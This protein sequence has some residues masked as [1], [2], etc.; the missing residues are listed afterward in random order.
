MSVTEPRTGARARQTFFVMWAIVATILGLML[1]GLVVLLFFQLRAERTRPPG[2]AGWSRWELSA[3]GNGHWYK[4]VALTN[5]V[6]WTEADRLARL[7]GGY[8]ATITSAAENDFVFSLVNAPE[9]FS[10]HG[11]GPALGGFQRDGSAEPNGGWGWVSGEPW[12]YHHWLPKEPNNGHSR[13][14]TED[15][16]QFY[17]GIPSTPAATWND[18]NRH[19]VNS[20]IAYVVE[21]N[22]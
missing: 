8:L 14:G 1:A 4:A 12:N 5:D 21:R 20:S 19:D 3:G 18:I 16:V 22:D 9:F 11:T 15:R 10:D 6:T 13:F 7:E 2:N 17:S